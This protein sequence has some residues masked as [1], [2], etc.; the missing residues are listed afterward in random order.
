M[1]RRAPGPLA[2]VEI[3]FVAR[4][5]GVRGEVRAVPHDPDSDAFGRVS[6]L[7]IGGRWFAVRRAR[8]AS[9]AWLL[10]LDQ[11]EDRDA[12]AAL[13]GAPVEARR[14]ELGLEEGEVLLAELVG[15][16]AVLRDGTRYGT[17]ADIDVGPGQSRLVIRD[18]ETERLVP[19]VDAIVVDVSLEEGRVVLDPPEGLP[20][21]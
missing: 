21:A 4:A 16:E 12:A 9:G 17:V 5:H 10:Q 1:G 20:E 2:K 11:V 14:E 19:I 15:C 13:A 8:Q 18:G 6:E 7:S 3:G